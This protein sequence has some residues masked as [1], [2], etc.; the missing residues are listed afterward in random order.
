MNTD[1]ESM[2]T[3]KPAPTGASARVEPLCVPPY[4]RVV[5]ALDGSVYAG[6]A[7]DTAAAIARAG[8]SRLESLTVT[9]PLMAKAI[10]HQV[11][12]QLNQAGA[13]ADRRRIETEG[14]AAS[15]VAKMMQD[16][17]TSIESS[18]VVATDRGRSHV[19]A[20][21]GSFAERVLAAT[22]GPLLLVGPSCRRSVHLGPHQ[23]LVVAVDDPAIDR[24]LAELV[25]RWSAVF[26]LDVELVHVRETRTSA[27]IVD[28]AN[29]V[30]ALRAIKDERQM[31][32]D[33][34]S[35]SNHGAKLTIVEDYSAAHGLVELAEDR[36]VAAIVIGSHSRTNFGRLVLGSVAMRVVRDSPCPVL[37][38]RPDAAGDAPGPD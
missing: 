20:V 14:E 31:A 30:A 38:V 28:S 18:L 6:R 26:D 8:G 10:G 35:A 37:V 3:A 23:R 22:G 4:T 27:S 34:A 33:I 7:I 5:A 11:E 17:R 36:G 12:S 19:G 13:S 32:E 15:V 25:A 2:T 29:W 1:T 9:E 16:D 21:T 24:R